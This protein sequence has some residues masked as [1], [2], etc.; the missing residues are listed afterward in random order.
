MSSSLFAIVHATARSPAT[1]TQLYQHHTLA[2]PVD[3]DAIN[4]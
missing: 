3:E 4:V 1:P 2:P